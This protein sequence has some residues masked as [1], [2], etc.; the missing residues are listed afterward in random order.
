MNAMH[1]L[2]F[3]VM[4]IVGVFAIIF[5]ALQYLRGIVG[6]EDVSFLILRL[7]RKPGEMVLA[8]STRTYKFRPIVDNSFL[9]LCMSIWLYRGKGILHIPNQK[10]QHALLNPF[11]DLFSD[12]ANTPYGVRWADCSDFR[13]VKYM[14]WITSLRSTRGRRKIRAV[15]MRLED[16]EALKA[17]ELKGIVF[18]PDLRFLEEVFPR[19]LGMLEGAGEFSEFVPLTKSTDP[20]LIA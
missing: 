7:P 5:G 19:L 3:G 14:F 8:C 6:A 18:H 17:S 1:L 11:V 2:R 10:W 20:T 9:Y 16:F 4:G 12:I 15:A 13:E